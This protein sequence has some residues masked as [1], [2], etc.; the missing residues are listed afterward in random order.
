MTTPKHRQWLGVTTLLAATAAI[1]AFAAVFGWP[2]LA[3]AQSPGPGA[4]GPRVGG[5]VHGDAPTPGGIGLMVTTRDQ[6]R[7]Q[8]MLQLQDQ[9]C[10]PLTLATLTDGRWHI[11]IPGGPAQLQ[12][13]F[14]QQLAADTPFFVRCRDAAPAVVR[15]GADDSGS[16][17]S[18]E[19]GQRLRVT[20]ESNP[21]TGY[22]WQ[23]TGAP[24]PAVLEQVLGPIYIGGA[25]DLVGAA[26]TETFDFLAVGAGT[27]SISLEYARPFEANS[28][29]DAWTIDVTVTAP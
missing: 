17:V 8:I 7:D 4:G 20:L 26:G 12:S 23:L 21:T 10:E 28:M 15:V 1:A 6:D 25:S 11:Y 18:L 14:P 24:D 5:G 13:D 16:S 3:S 2:G 19:V 9:D 22:S 29:T 27:T